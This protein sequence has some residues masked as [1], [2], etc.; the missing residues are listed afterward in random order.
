MNKITAVFTLLLCIVL[1]SACGRAPASGDTTVGAT[2]QSE[3]ND[4]T[5]RTADSTVSTADNTVMV[6][7]NSWLML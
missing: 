5:V 6:D 4:S 2:E 1:I 7:N 3:K